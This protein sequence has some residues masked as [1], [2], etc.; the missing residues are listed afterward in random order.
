MNKHFLIAIFS[1]SIL[2]LSCKEN[3]DFDAAGNFEADEVIV[4]A[5][6]NGTILTFGVTEGQRLEKNQV[7]GQI[8]VEAQ[9]LQKEQT[10]ATISALQQKTVT[11]K[12]QI[13]VVRK[14]M[15][16]QQV[17][18][19]QLQHEKKRTQNLVNADAA[20]RKQLDDIIASINQLNSQMAATRAQVE[21]YQTNAATQN[22]SILSE[23]APIERSAAVIQNQ[24]EKGQIMNPLAGTVLTKY[25]MAG[26]MATPGRPLYKIANIDTLNLKAYVTGQQLPQLKIGQTVTARI[27]DGKGGYKNYPGVISWISDKAEFTP[28]TIQTKKEREN[29]VYAIKVRVNNDGFL[30][31]GMYGEVLFNYEEREK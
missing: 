29:L 30:K 20:P 31:I 21:L 14:Q 16:A 22:R 17:Q 15:A 25:A 27:D 3:K 11:P 23:R 13:E 1:I 24:I 5:Q 26:E 19:D 28:K 6:Q 18:M 8:D 2:L 4:S 7:I 12:A 10:Q 9:R